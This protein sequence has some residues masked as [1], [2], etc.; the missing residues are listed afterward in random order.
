[1]PVKYFCDFCGADIT[2]ATNKKLLPSVEQEEHY[3]S[4]STDG[5]YYCT[6]C[7]RCVEH[8]PKYAELVKQIV[9]RRKIKIEEQKQKQ[10][11]RNDPSEE[12]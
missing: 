5:N 11:K 6:A 8:A 9:L 2:E 7:W 10:E 12:C 1:M 4:I 3:I